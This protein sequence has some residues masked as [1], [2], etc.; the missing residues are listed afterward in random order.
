LE[1]DEMPRIRTVDLD[2]KN[3]LAKRGRGDDA[4]SRVRDALKQGMKIWLVTSER[5]R[6]KVAELREDLA[7]VVIEARQEYESQADRSARTDADSEAVAAATAPRRRAT[8]TQAK[9]GRHAET[10]DDPKEAKRE[11]TATP[12]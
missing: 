10:T 11:Q 8:R 9:R 7:A 12:S 4:E 3:R 5:V 2:A 1:E 6:T